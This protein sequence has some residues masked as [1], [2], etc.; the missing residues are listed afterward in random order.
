MTSELRLLVLEDNELDAEL[1]ER[2]LTKA[3]L[4]ITSI[5]VDTE[6]SY[7]EALNTFKPTVVLSDFSLPHFDGLSAL[8]LARR[9]APDVPF[10]FVSGSIDEARAAEAMQRGATGYVLK[11]RL[12]M[13]APVV[14]RAIQE[15]AQRNARHT[16]EDELKAMGTCNS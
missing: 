9:L 15:A 3:G 1:A 12:E 11:D 2:A 14:T 13:L 5:R 16:A 6:G 8:D 10:I 7:V 4:S